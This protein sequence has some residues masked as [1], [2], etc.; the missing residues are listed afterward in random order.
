VNVAA[1]GTTISQVNL[2]DAAAAA[3]AGTG[4]THVKVPSDKRTVPIT[5]APTGQA[6]RISMASME[7]ANVRVP[8]SQAGVYLA[9]QVAIPVGLQGVSIQPVMV[10][11][12]MNQDQLPAVA[13]P[14]DLRGITNFK[15]GDIPTDLQGVSSYKLGEMVHL[16]RA[17]IPADLKDVTSFKVGDL[18]HL[19][20]ADIPADLQG[21]SYKQG[22]MVSLKQG[23]LITLK[24]APK[25]A[26]RPS[27][28]LLEVD[29]ESADVTTSSQCLVLQDEV[30]TVLA[31][32]RAK[33]GISAKSVEAAIKAARKLIADSDKALLALRA[34]S[35]V[36]SQRVAADVA[37]VEVD[38]LAL[39]KRMEEELHLRN[40][41]LLHEL[42]SDCEYGPWTAWSTTCSCKGELSRYRPVLVPSAHGGVCPA[43]REVKKCSAPIA[44]TDRIHDRDGRGVHVLEEAG[45][46]KD[47]VEMQANFGRSTHVVEVADTDPLSRVHLQV[48]EVASNEKGQP[49]ALKKVPALWNSR[50]KRLR[51]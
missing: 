14:E 51:L 10:P 26:L 19:K 4:I 2:A 50:T 35:E 41:A 45:T 49:H 5:A 47:V 31:D 37:A 18:V 15:R 36:I 9:P 3:L 43:V 38:S 22:D 7:Y 44:C 40:L 17:D 23:S 1:A 28:M 46:E 42:P 32:F 13:I 24:K 25:S 21:L 30:S 33:T 39:S 20:R 11:T 12:N 6:S 48:M 16:K 27:M 29:S 34:Q 8:S